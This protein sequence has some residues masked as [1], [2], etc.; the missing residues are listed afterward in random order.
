MREKEGIFY[1]EKKRFWKK[2]KC[3]F[4]CELKNIVKK[5]SKGRWLSNV[6]ETVLLDGISFEVNRSEKEI[7]PWQTN[8]F[9]LLLFLLLLR[10]ESISL[11]PN[12]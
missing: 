7:I 1:S 3:G 11:L 9:L 8:L 12:E 2:K 10:L 6:N 5:R 4:W